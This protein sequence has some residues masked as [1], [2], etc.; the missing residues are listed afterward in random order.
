LVE[1]LRLYSNRQSGRNRLR[2]IRL[3]ALSEHRPPSKAA[4]RQRMS[5]LDPSAEGELIDSYRSGAKIKELAQEFRVHRT[6]VTSLLLR[7][8]VE[9]RQ[10]GLRPDQVNE[11][12]RLYRSGW[13]LATL[14]DKFGVDDMTV[15]RYLLLAGVVMRSPAERLRR[16]FS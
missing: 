6:T 9:L 14:G 10:V 4:P 2:D 1:L 3:E 7:C 15:R 11:A 5:H 13:S 8:G 12:S 16:N